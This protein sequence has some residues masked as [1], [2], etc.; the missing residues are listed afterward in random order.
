MNGAQLIN[1]NHMYTV[2][3]RLL[4]LNID[5]VHQVTGKCIWNDWFT[6]YIINRRAARKTQHIWNDGIMLRFTT[7]EHSVIKRFIFENGA[8]K[9]KT[10]NAERLLKQRQN[11]KIHVPI[12]SCGCKTLASFA[13]AFQCFSMGPIGFFSFR[14]AIKLI[15]SSSYNMIVAAKIPSMRLTR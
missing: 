10:Q 11:V 8:H 14:T 15:H 5:L 4:R 3:A 7:A 9:K 6:A 2:L 1:L 13:V 12:C